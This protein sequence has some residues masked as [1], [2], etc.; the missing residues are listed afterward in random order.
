M[1][2]SILALLFSIMVNVRSSEE[3]PFD[4]QNPL[5]EFTCFHGFRQR[6]SKAHYHQGDN[7]S[8]FCELEV[9]YCAYIPRS[10]DPQLV[11]AALSPSSPTG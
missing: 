6:S 9:S 4:T 8:L 1:S 10:A 2:T 5:T 11:L 3:F 7:Q